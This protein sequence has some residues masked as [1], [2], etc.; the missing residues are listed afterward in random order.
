ML[1]A[2]NIGTSRQLTEYK[3]I[4]YITM[5]D[6]TVVMTL[7]DLVGYRNHVRLKAKLQVI[8]DHVKPYNAK[9]A[10]R[11]I[12]QAKK[13]CCIPT[14]KKKKNQGPREFE[15]TTRHVPEAEFAD[16]TQYLVVED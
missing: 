9:K 12:A 13:E 7:K 16:I 6:C 14:T 5:K 2:S 4:K 1:P 11:L 3:Y 15:L 8:N 10:A